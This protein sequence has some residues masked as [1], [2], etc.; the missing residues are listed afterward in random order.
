MGFAL[1]STHP[2]YYCW[3]PPI[4]P[5]ERVIPSPSKL[6]LSCRSTSTRSGPHLMA[7]RISPPLAPDQKRL[8]AC[9]PR[10]RTDLRQ[11]RRQSRARDLAAGYW[12]HTLR[13]EGDFVR[14]L[15]YIHFNPVKH[16]HAVRVQDW[17]FSSVPIRWIGPAIPPMTS[18]AL[19]SDDGFRSRPTH[20]T[21][22]ATTVA[23]YRNF[24]PGTQPTPPYS[25][26]L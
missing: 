13:D 22:Y 21:R 18:P 5:S 6:P 19:V 9:F 25:D 15:D 23:A 12:E 8:F 4:A 20:P 3:A 10:R 24:S 2:T 16:G 26:L 1:R 7:T 17:P 14:H 11:P